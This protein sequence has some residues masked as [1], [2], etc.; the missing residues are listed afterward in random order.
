MSKQNPN[1]FD[2]AGRV[3]FVGMPIYYT[4][5]MS[6]RILVIEVWVN[7]KYKQEVAFDFVNDK[8]DMVNNIRVDDRV[9]IA[10]QLRGNKVIQA[11]GKARWFNNLEG[12]AVTK[13]EKK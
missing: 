3:L 7:E 5:K 8:M 1:L 12:L 9:D 13:L 4:E 11:D 6:K 2:I 10:F